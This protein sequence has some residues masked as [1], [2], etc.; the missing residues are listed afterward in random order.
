MQLGDSTAQLELQRSKHLPANDAIANRMR[1]MQTG[2]SWTRLREIDE[3]DSMDDYD[4]QH[5][6]D[7]V[8]WRCGQVGGSPVEVETL[9]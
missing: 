6:A 9:G 2:W 4:E 3:H 8:G 5:G 1:H 7:Q